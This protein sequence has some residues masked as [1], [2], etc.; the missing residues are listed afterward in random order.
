ML[1]VVLVVVLPHFARAATD[2]VTANGIAYFLNARPPQVERYDLQAQRFLAAIP[3]ESAGVSFWVSD[4]ALFVA[5]GTNVV[6]SSLD[7]SNRVDLV[8]V[9]DN[10][11]GIVGVDDFLFIAAGTTMTSV[12]ADTGQIIDTRRYQNRILGGI[13]LAAER[14]LIV[15]RAAGSPQDIVFTQYAL[16]GNLGDQFDSP[17]HGDLEYAERVWVVPG[18]SFVVDE[19]ATVYSLDDFS[20]G[21]SLG[22]RVDDI[23]FSE[24]HSIVARGRMLS[25]YD[26]RFAEVGRAHTTSE[27]R[28]VVVHDAHAF[29]FA[30][31]GTV[32]IV[33]LSEFSQPR[34]SVPPEPM[35]LPYAPEAIEAGTDDVI[36]LLSAAARAVYRW[37]PDERRYAEGIGLSDVPH[38][39]AYSRERNSLCIQ[40]S[41]GRLTEIDLTPPFAERPITSVLPNA[42][43]LTALDP[44][45][46][47]E[48]EPFRFL[49]AADG[50]LA[51]LNERLHLGSA[52]SWHASTRRLYSVRRDH[53]VAW[54]V[55]DEIGQLRDGNSAYHSPAYGPIVVSP[56]GDKA[57]L[58]SGLVLDGASLEG[59]G[60]LGVDQILD[61]AWKDDDLYTLRPV[62]NA[63]LLQRWDG[64]YAPAGFTRIAGTPMR[65]LS[66]NSGLLVITLA[67]GRPVFTFA[68]T[69]ADE[70][71]DGVLDP[72]DNCIDIANPNQIDSD[73]DQAGDACD[74]F[75]RDPDDD[76]IPAEIDN[77]PDAYNPLQEDRDHDT[78]GDLCDPY[79]DLLDHMAACL[80]EI[81]ACRAT[82][83]GLIAEVERLQADNDSL[84]QELDALRGGLGCAGDLDGDRSVTVDEI[85]RSVTNALHGCPG[86]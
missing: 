21:G 17:Y 54:D 8:T 39:M 11:T 78:V 43:G 81:G 2:Q 30:S 40:Y 14:R 19:S 55:I 64:T 38:G 53:T 79:P 80:E 59:I 9:G 71:G 77:C 35:T 27:T 63:T 23:D 76:G 3:L 29:A 52:F 85:V 6:R 74:P 5:R 58:G 65:I 60:N 37:L 34:A 42:H 44:F 47:L 22:D 72:L 4:S 61:A 49:Y 1:G 68:E 75:P 56:A 25:T 69:A 57:V 62:D 10:I 18:E 66:L 67:G 50:T 26:R 12:S 84:R 36:Y 73:G 31:N 20:F 28:F 46:F 33:P 48:R 16:G 32:Q 45:L 86:S 41:S 70:D 15:G 7:G 83:T 82:Q 13:S 24:G 51:K